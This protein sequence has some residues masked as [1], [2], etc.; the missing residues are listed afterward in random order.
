M[1]FVGGVSGVGFENLNLGF[2][3]DNQARL[4]ALRDQSL[5]WPI[6]LAQT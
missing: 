4:F 6:R 1:G 3:R 2:Q 5:G